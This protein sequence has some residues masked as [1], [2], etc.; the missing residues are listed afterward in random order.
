M[1]DMN[2]PRPPTEDRPPVASPPPAVITAEH[3]FAGAR[4]IHITYQ[5]E[6]YRLRI[7]RRGR[8]ILTK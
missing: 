2:E 3:L 7:T 4:E 6:T 5:G 1:T 8:L